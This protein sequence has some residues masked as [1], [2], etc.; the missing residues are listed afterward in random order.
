M[1]ADPFT[2]AIATSSDKLTG[3]LEHIKIVLMA[4]V[5]IVIHQSDQGC[6]TRFALR[7]TRCVKVL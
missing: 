2:A 6:L 3:K 7:F 5:L 1:D 4:S